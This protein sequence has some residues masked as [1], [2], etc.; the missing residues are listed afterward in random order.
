MALLQSIKTT[1]RAALV[2][3]AL[4]ATAFTAM[5]VQAAGPSGSFSIQLGNGMSNNGMFFN[6]GGI[7][8]H[9]GDDDFFNFCLTDRQIERGLERHGFR[10]ADVVKHLNNRKV[11]AVARYSG[12]WY[13]LRVDRCSGKVDQ[14]K[15]IKRK[16]NGNF[17]FSLNF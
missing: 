6:K 2:A 4:G 16:S 13:Q 8:L 14:V 1:G 10:S 7:T 15:K 11:L 12:S 9:F 5:P 17:S 3:V